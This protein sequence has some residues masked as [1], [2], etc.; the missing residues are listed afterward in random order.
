[1]RER[2]RENHTERRIQILAHGQILE[3]SQILLIFPETT[4]TATTPVRPCSSVP[5]HIDP[6]CSVLC[7]LRAVI[8]ISQPSPHC[9]HCQP[10]LPHLPTTPKPAYP[11]A[12][13][14]VKMMG[15]KISHYSLEMAPMIPIGP[16]HSLLDQVHLHAHPIA[17]A[18]TCVNS[19][20]AP[21]AIP[22]RIL[23]TVAI[24]KPKSP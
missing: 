13:L 9:L 6:Q 1:M 10:A 11:L 8:K 4:Y 16:V 19:L 17:T 15:H 12:M 2:E 23:I 14:S 20:S 3:Q 24:R 5:R 7:A 21:C 22:I 18:V